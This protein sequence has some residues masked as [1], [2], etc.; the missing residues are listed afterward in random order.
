MKIKYVLTNPLCKPEL[1]GNLFDLKSAENIKF[2][3]PKLVNVVGNTEFEKKLQ[4]DE[5]MVS[6]GIILKLPKYIRADLQG[7]SSTWTK[8]KLLMGNSRGI[9][10]G[11]T[12]LSKKVKGITLGIENDLYKCDKGYNGQKDVWK[13]PLLATSATEIKAGER[14]AQFELLLTM[15]APWWFRL[16]W[17]LKRKIIFEEVAI[18][19][20]SN[21]S[22][23]GSSGK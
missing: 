10:D 16:K 12:S 17:V 8:H 11:D 4:W 19:N 18:L 15:D 2:E 23:F 5:K 13:I 20:T 14:I 7:R 3:D 6:L 22:G 21:R 1:H 9:I